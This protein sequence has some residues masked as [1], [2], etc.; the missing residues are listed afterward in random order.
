MSGGW[1]K[2]G[3]AAA[4]EGVEGCVMRLTGPLAGE[5]IRSGFLK[6]RQYC[7]SGVRRVE[8]NE[9]SLTCCRG[10]TGAAMIGFGDQTPGTES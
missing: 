2:E 7:C 1:V 6:V 3:N 10:R 8:G 4:E 9:A 5:G